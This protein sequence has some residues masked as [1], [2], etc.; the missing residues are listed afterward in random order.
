MFLVA[1]YRPI[2][3]NKSQNRRRQKQTATIST[4]LTI[5]DGLISDYLVFADISDL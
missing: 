3:L 4:V 2:V 5:D 1:N